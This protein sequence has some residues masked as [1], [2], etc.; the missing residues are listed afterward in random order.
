MTTDEIRQLYLRF[1]EEKGHLILPS[2]SLVPQGDPTLL[3]TSA[4]MV[5][6]KPYFLGEPIPPGYRSRITTCQKCFRTTDIDSVGDTKHL[7]FFE[8]LGNFSIADYFKK[9]AIAWAWELVTQRLKLPKDRLWIT[10]YLDDDEAFRYWREQGVPADR[11]KRFGEKDNFWGPAGEMGPCGPSS[12]IHY[13][14]G[15]GVGCGRAECAPNCDCARYLEIW[16]LVFVQF[17][18]DRN[19][20]RTPLPNPHIDTGMGLERIAAVMQGKVSVYDTDAFT[21]LLDAVSWLAG[22]ERGEDDIR[23]RALRVV[24]EHARSVTFLI[25]DGVVPSNEGRGYVLRRVLRR[26]SVFGRRLG[27]DKPFLTEVS[28]QVI[29][30]MGHV[31]PELVKNREFILKIIETEEGK[32]QEVIEAGLNWLDKSISRAQELG[33]KQIPGEEVFTLYDTYGFPSELTAEIGRERGLSVDME[34]FKAE[35]EKQRERSRAAHK[36]ALSEERVRLIEKAGDSLAQFPQTEFTGYE[37]LSCPAR[38]LGL[39][40]DG[41]AENAVSEGQQVEVVLDRTPFYAEMGG[42]VADTGEI[43]GEKGVVQV[44][45]TQWG[46]PG[47]VVHRGRVTSGALVS[48]EPVT[49]RVE[50]GR[51]LDIA[52]NHTATHLLHAA[53][54]RVL[55]SH[56]L[57]RGSLVAPDR[58]RFDY[59]HLLTPSPEELAQVQ[60]LVNGWIRQDLPVKSELKS[61]REAVAQGAIALFGEKYGEKVR[62]VAMGDPPVSIELCGGTHLHGAAGQIGFFV[63]VSEGSIGSGLRRIEALTGRGAETYIQ[64]RLATLSSLTKELQA[65]PENVQEKL[66]ALLE[67]LSKERKRAQSLERELSKKDAQGLLAQVQQVDGVA[68]LASRVSVSGPEALREMGDRLRDSLQSAIVVLGAVYNDKPSFLTLVTPDLVKRGFHAAEIV[69]QVARIAG[70]GGGGRPEMAQA[71]GKDKERLD[72]ALAAVKAIVQ[73]RSSRKDK[74]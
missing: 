27:L 41:K 40:L 63:I 18:Q 37:E 62:A 45:D 8:M 4:G 36:F 29:E 38:I 15:E 39:V 57:Q 67:E 56:A 6:F 3:L 22:V 11:I 58:L 49:A 2:S 30:Q 35:A 14:Y 65:T 64:G 51:R 9:E 33:N 74:K 10:I 43:I 53:L 25:A 1:F 34:G 66:A 50:E 55:G 46:R 31:Y 21:P 72:E 44:E 20:K 26:A 16:N 23:G 17:N 59:S 7:T 28:Q 32:F 61:Y 73:E 19:G 48:G 71:G 5:Q 24:A 47:I 70:G 42:Q 52:R 68:V 13:D 54:R 69:K 60:T 12:E